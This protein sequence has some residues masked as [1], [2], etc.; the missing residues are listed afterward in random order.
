MQQYQIKFHFY[1]LGFQN[2]SDLKIVI[3]WW[4]FRKPSLPGTSLSRK[5]CTEGIQSLYSLSQDSVIYDCSQGF[6]LFCEARSCA[7]VPGESRLLAR[8]QFENLGPLRAARLPA[9]ELR[10]EQS[11]E[12][13]GTDSQELGTPKPSLAP[14]LN[15]S[16]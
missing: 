14:G 8:N 11:S 10:S 16:R 13:C 1:I 3:S 7:Q 12:R 5:P 6:S 9:M 15:E 2:L 4:N